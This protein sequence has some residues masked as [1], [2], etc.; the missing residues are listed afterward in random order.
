MYADIKQSLVSALQPINYW[1]R[2]P[3]SAAFHSSCS[4]WSWGVC[5]RMLVSL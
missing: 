5:C 2:V 1:L 4:N 3:C